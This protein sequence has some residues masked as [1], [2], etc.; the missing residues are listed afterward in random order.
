MTI[1]SQYRGA[2]V[3]RIEDPRLLT[4]RG[5]FVDDLTPPGLWHVVVVRSPHAH[6]RVRRIRGGRRAAVVTARDLGGPVW[7]PV[8][9]ED[10][11]VARHPVLAGDRVC[12]VGQPVAA[13]LAR[14]LAQAVDAAAAIEVDY[15]PLPAVVQAE[16]ALRP[17]AVVVH[18][19]LKTNVAVH[20][21]WTRGGVAQVFRGAEVTVAQ[22]IVH[23]RVAAVSLEGRAVLATPPHGS[24][25]TLTVW[26]S[27]QMPHALRDE[28]TAF[29]PRRVPVR[30][31]AP[32]VGGGFGV[33]INIYPEEFL[34]PLLALRL[35]RPLK[36]VE[37]RREHLQATSHGR[38]QFADVRLAASRDGRILG[39]QLHVVA[40]VGAYLLS[41]TADVPPLTLEM[42][43]G[44]YDIRAV[45]V[46]LLEVYTNKV[47]TGAYRGAGRPEATF[48]LERAMDIL[49]AQIGRD[50]AEVRRRNFISPDRFPYRAP[51]G[52]SYDSGNYALTLDRALEACGYGELREEQTRARE[53]GRCLG[54][55][56]SS[57]VETCTYGGDVSRVALD[58]DGKVTVY[59]GT[60]PHGQGGA[61]GFA[62]IVADALGVDVRQISVVHGDTAVI[63]EGEGTAG[64]RTLV[65]GGSAAYRGALVLRRKLLRRAARKLEAALEDLVMS[66]GRIH[67]TGVPARS[68]SLAELVGNTS[69]S[70]AGRF[71]VRGS[72]FPFGTH[73]AVV[74]VDPDTGAIRLLRH[75][76]V[77]DC[78]V[79]INPLLVEGQI[80]GGVAQAV[81]QAL[82]EDVHYD[83]AGQLI[84][85]SL[86]EYAVPRALMM[87]TITTLRTETPSPRNPLGAKGVGEAGTIGATPAVVNAVIDAL[88][89]FGVRH[90]DMPLTPEKIWAA[91]RVSPGFLTATG[92]SP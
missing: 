4:G 25:R 69:L 73:V 67:V 66:G 50:P 71:S 59:S 46:D 14:T 47:P 3:K 60:S 68:V 5:A 75:V 76:A 6:A 30:V 11:T 13:V 23:Q 2:R 39:L 87:P 7:L 81:G 35:G 41:T 61:T 17:D 38:S 26:C 40:D 10:G 54:I 12:Y 79:V 56:L 64:S 52:V 34:I 72:T 8:E 28:L 55:G 57:Y 49:A 84:T 24:E 91:V 33:K 78:G 32:D 89:P 31:I 16:Q 90:L 15:D 85:G 1:L 58:R 44:P 43:S 27:T 63:P 70:A 9:V 37:N 20:R 65:V 45:G 29:L 42:A 53:A 62:Q 74:E 86:A 36:W 80:H 48:Y 18:P 51:S 82:Y 22:R 19:K 83:E 21:R 92:L 88:S 77:D